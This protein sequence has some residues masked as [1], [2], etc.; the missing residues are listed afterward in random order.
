MKRDLLLLLAAAVAGCAPRHTITGHIDSLT[1]DSLC[2]VHCAIEDMPGLKGD[3][4]QRITYDTIVAANGRFAYDTPVE[5]PTQFIIIPMQL[6]EFDQGRRHSTS[7]SDMKLFLDKGEQV[8]IEGRIDSTV[9]NCT[10]SGT[11]LN[12]DHSRH[13]QELRSFWIEGQRLQDAMAGKSRA[14]QEALYERFRQVMARRRACEMDYID[15]NPDN[16]LAGYCLTKIPIDSVLTYHERLADAARNSIFRPLLEP[17]LAKAGKYRLIRL[18]EAKIV[19]GSPAPDFTLKTADDKNFTLSSLRGK[20]VVLDFW[21][22]WCGWCIKGIP[23][24]KRYYD[25]YKSKLEIVGIDCNDTPE[26]W[27][28]AVGRTPAAVD[29]RLQSERRSG[30][31]RHLRRICCQRIPHQGDH[32]SRRPHHRKIRGR[33]TRFLRGPAQDDP[34]AVF[35]LLQ[36]KPRLECSNRGLRV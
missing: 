14:E 4:D 6:M 24:M 10:L 9:F 11:R 29:Q 36:R 33:R 5:R 19:A 16:P 3:D 7:T 26:R 22:S 31:G 28:A 2:I 23:K 17:L 35:S 15:A 1:N 13:Y 25:R 34:I 32:R 20:Y 12:E 18:A 30:S 8:K 21:G 27:L